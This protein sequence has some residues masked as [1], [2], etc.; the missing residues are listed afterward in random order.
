MDENNRPNPSLLPGAVP[1]ACENGSQQLWIT[2]YSAS[3]PNGQCGNSN[4]TLFWKPHNPHLWCRQVFAVQ[5]LQRQQHVR[6][7]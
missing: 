5:S 2:A 3:S 4:Y 6:G 7:A 1:T